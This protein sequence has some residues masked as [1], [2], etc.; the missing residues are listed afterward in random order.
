MGNCLVLENEN[1]VWTM[2]KNILGSKPSGPGE[3]PSLLFRSYDTF[4]IRNIFFTHNIPYKYTKGDLRRKKDK[5][6]FSEFIEIS[7]NFI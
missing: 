4:K 7:I 2:Y 1:I 5:F 3:N 6:N